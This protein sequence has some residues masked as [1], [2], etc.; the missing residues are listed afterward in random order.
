MQNINLSHFTHIAGHQDARLV[1]RNNTNESTLTTASEGFGGRVLSFLGQ[2]PIF[3][4]ITAVREHV[5]KI[6]IENKITV[7]AFANALANSYGT[8]AADKI[9]THYN[10]NSG[11]TPLTQR[12]IQAI[13]LP[14]AQ[15][16]KAKESFVSELTHQYGPNVAQQ[17]LTMSHFIS[18][19][20]NKNDLSASIIMTNNTT[21]PN[22]NAIE[23][24]AKNLQQAALTSAITS[25]TK[26]EKLQ[27]I[28]GQN[29]QTHF[30]QLSEGNGGLRTLQTL[31]TNL[32]NLS[33]I[34]GMEEFQNTL[35]SVFVGNSPFSQWGTPGGRVE[36]WV[37]TA[38]H[39]ELTI[40]A[41][42]IQ[43]IVQDVLTLKDKLLAHQNGHSVHIEKPKLNLHRF[44]NISVTPET[45][46]ILQDKT[47]MPA[48]LVLTKGQPAAIA[49]SYPKGTLSALE[50]HLRMILEQKPSCLVVLTG[51]DQIGAKKLPDYFRRS[52][53]V[54]TVNTQ[55][56]QDAR[57]LT[58][59]GVEIDNYQLKISSGTDT[60]T[61]PVIHVQNWKDHQALRSPY[62]LLE[63]AQMTLEISTTN[64]AVYENIE[65]PTRV[66][67]VHCFGGVGRTGTLITALELIKNPSLSSEQIITDLRTTRNSKMA[68][69]RPQQLQ[70]RQLEQMLGPKNF[71][72]TRL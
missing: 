55:V 66:P 2:F 27:K 53:T 46:I 13:L 17:A 35:K 54:G 24:L 58:P 50:S 69:D 9:V 38:S 36:A 18:A 41:E 28:S 59:S 63:L 22:Y 72:S 25:L 20:S 14:A 68:E 44:S 6:K 8:N 42:R 23:T 70:L 12:K 62:Q 71:I 39:S 26:L 40:A 67:M 21:T 4:R 7:A 10:L 37:K 47:P 34:P 56:T 19:G 30:T 5:E 43:G 49:C 33:H 52:E 16:M 51:D 45:Q 61:L 32:S 11:D 48:N 1:V 31:L 15:M 57:V 64:E 65:T 60:Y 3:Q 29:I